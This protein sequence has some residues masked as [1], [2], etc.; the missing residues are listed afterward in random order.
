MKGD[1]IYMY[2]IGGL[3]SSVCAPLIGKIADKRGRYKVFVVLSILACIPL[4]AISN[5]S[6]TAFWTMI[7]ASALFFVFSGGRM[8]PA[9]A[10]ITS[11]VTP[12][13]R[14]SY[15]SLNSA[16]QQLTVGL[17]TLIG[18]SIIYNDELKKLHNYPYVGYIGIGFGLVALFAGQFIKPV[19][20]TPPTHK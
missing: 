13:L 5:F 1:L 12:H 7:G 2:V 9:Q 4:Y 18:G 15:M 17:S 16:M 10:M 14:G 11:V 6:S 20:H 3:L 19:A 8:V